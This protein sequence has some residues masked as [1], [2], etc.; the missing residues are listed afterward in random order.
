M[1]VSPFVKCISKPSLKCATIL[2]LSTLG[3]GTPS[4]VFSLISLDIAP[5][6]RS[7][8]ILLTYTPLNAYY[9]KL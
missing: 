3:V 9:T 1:T 5:F 4:D 7:N 6:G 2:S 8:V